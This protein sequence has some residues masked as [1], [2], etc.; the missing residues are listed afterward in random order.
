MRTVVTAWTQPTAR[1]P[2]QLTRVSSHTTA[3]VTTRRGPGHARDPGREGARVAHRAGGDRR[4]AHPH[5]DPVAPGHHEARQLPEGRARVDVGPAVLREGPAE[6]GEHGGEQES[7]GRGEQPPHQAVP[8]VG[9][10][11]RRQHVDAGPDD[12]AHHQGRRHPEAQLLDLV[13]AHESG[14]SPRAS[15][16]PTPTHRLT[17]AR[18]ARAPTHLEERGRAEPG[19]AR[20]EGMAERDRHRRSG[21]RSPR[22]RA[23]PGPACRPAPVR[24]RPR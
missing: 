12:V 6:R 11:R 3:I 2:Q 18:R 14:S 5:R 24:R 15:P 13:R 9:R 8:A 23:A 21:S 19:P 17:I 4:V 7:A 16:C 20:A 10:E 1:T 22:R